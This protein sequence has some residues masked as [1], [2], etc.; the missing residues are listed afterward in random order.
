[1]KFLHPPVGFNGLIIAMMFLV[2]GCFEP[3]GENF[4]VVDQPSFAGADINLSNAEG[5]LYID[6]PTTLTLRSKFCGQGGVVRN[7]PH[8]YLSFQDKPDLSKY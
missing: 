6:R 7:G 3:E 2:A 5:A 4:V 1:L 8:F